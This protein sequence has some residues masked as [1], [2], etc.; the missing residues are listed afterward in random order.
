[1]MPNRKVKTYAHREGVEHHLH[2]YLFVWY[3]CVSY[4][5]LKCGINLY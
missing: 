4:T 2:N 5:H 1:M 3:E